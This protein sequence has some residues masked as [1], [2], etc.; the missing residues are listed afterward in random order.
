MAAGI[1]NHEMEDVAVIEARADSL[2]SSVI[3]HVIRDVIGFV[4]YMHQQI[5]SI[6]Q[7]LSAEYDNLQTECEAKA[8]FRRQQGGRMREVKRGI[9]KLQKL[10]NTVN[11]LE[12]ALRL[13]ITEVPGM[14][15]VILIL[16]SSPIRPHHVYEFCFSHGNSVSADTCDFTRNR[17]VEGL[18]RKAIR[19][20]ITKGAGSGSYP[21][22][23]K[24]FLLVKAPSS[25][26]SPF[27][28]LPKRDFKYSKKVVPFTVRLKCRSQGPAAVDHNHTSHTSSFEGTKDS[29][30]N[31]LIWFQC[32]HVIKGLAFK[33]P[34]EE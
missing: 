25:F 20:L 28:F 29:A 7:D 23:T 26:N 31:D 14:E 21:G 3:F 1:V 15:S 24:L 6:L 30:S 34:D 13:I 9:R 33:I 19:A 5:P 8:S 2:G 27:H 22:P 11:I 17:V 4:L 16:G 18:A 10:M 12:S 32:R